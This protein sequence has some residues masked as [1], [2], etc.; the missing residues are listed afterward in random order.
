MSAA[1][2][3]F[4]AMTGCDTVSSF[5]GEGK[6]TAFEVWKACPDATLGFNAASNGSIGEAME[7]LEKFVVA[8]YDM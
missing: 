2:P 3:M 1:L 4:Y 5:S 7:Y 6:R 8:M